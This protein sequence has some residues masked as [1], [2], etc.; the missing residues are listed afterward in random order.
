M[1]F[2][3][4]VVLRT[5]LGAN[6]AG[7]VYHHDLRNAQQLVPGAP[8]VVVHVLFAG[9][10]NRIGKLRNLAKAGSQ[11]S[12]GIGTGSGKI[13][14]HGLEAT[15]SQLAVELVQRLSHAHA[16]LGL[17]KKEL[18]HHLLVFYNDTAPTEIYS[19]SLH[20]SLLL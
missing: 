19:L 5:G 2:Q 3:V 15:R 6:Y 7:A 12:I 4:W 1:I 20:D 16:V 8:Q 9:V 11:R 18:D 17:Q 10:A 13:Y 14:G